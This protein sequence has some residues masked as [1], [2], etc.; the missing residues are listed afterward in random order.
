M[1]AMLWIGWIGLIALVAEAGMALWGDRATQ[2]LDAAGYT[3]IERTG[4]RYTLTCRRAGGYEPA[5]TAVRSDGQRVTG[6][7]CVDMW[8]SRHGVHPD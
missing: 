2:L 3:Q 8:A 5:F 4:Y 7:V 6:V 1:K